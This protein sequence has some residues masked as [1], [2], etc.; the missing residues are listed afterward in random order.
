MYGG[1]RAMELSS[2]SLA[3]PVVPVRRLCRDRGRGV[4]GGVASGLAAHL[5]VEVLVVRLAFVL[6]LL[7]GGAG[8]LMYVAFW[9]LV[10]QAPM[11]VVPQA[12]MGVVPQAPM[13]VVPQATLEP[14]R[15]E[16]QRARDRGQL[17]AFGAIALGGIL[18][19]TTTGLLASALVWPALLGGIGI[20]LIWQQ[21]DD[22]QRDRWRAQVPSRLPLLGAGRRWVAVVR[23]LLGAVLVAAGVATFFAARGD[24]RAALDGLL[25]TAVVL[26]GLVLIGGP[27]L[28]RVLSD[29][30]DERRERIR[31]QER[32]ELAAHL[33]DS[34]LQ[35]L[36]LIQRS[37]DDPR[38]VAR[39]AR[40]QERDL[41]A[42]LYA[43]ATTSTG[44]L[45]EVL[46]TAAAEIEDAHGV[47]IEVIAV[48]D[49]PL[50]ERLAALVTASREAMVNAAKFA[51]DTAISVYA[52]VDD[53]R[54][55]VFV[56]DRG[57]GFD[58]EADYPGR[59]GIAQSIRGRLARVGGRA[60]IRS[61]AGDGT[62]VE[63]SLTRSAA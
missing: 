30:G 60:T 36:A 56:R 34:V 29:L 59:Y 4:V 50:D 2:V 53:D 39:L 8:G 13:G 47:A 7:A 17:L 35:T 43:P 55:T 26:L 54:V 62:E 10:P 27:L 42:W 51:G 11:G 44:Q 12:P 57:P 28:R 31:S 33:H 38:E 3:P 21:A 24:F 15:G 23:L 46:E 52:E 19:G 5:G 61:G 32:A 49:C 9:A 22:D 20:G 63:L 14:E 6:L 48:G 41:R 16:P 40:G 25:A 1:G 58:P 37:A 45:R 18:L